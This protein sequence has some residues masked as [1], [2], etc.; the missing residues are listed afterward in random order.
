MSEVLSIIAI[1][2]C[3][4]AHDEKAPLGLSAAGYFGVDERVDRKGMMIQTLKGSMTGLCREC[5]FSGPKA[6]NNR[7]VWRCR[8]KRVE[9]IEGDGCIVARRLDSEPVTA[10]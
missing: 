4:E 10:V 7:W 6:V 5:R 2:S 9:I 8:H 3:G 1:E